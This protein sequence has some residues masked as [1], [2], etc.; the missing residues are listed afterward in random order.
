MPPVASANLLQLLTI[1]DCV[2]PG[3]V[4]A[5]EVAAEVVVVVPPETPTQY[6]S[7]AQNE[8]PQFSPLVP[9]TLFQAYSCAGVM[10]FCVA[11]S[12]H[13]MPP[14]ASAYLLH[15]LIIPD[16]VGPG[17]DT[18]VVDVVGLLVPGH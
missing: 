1:P 10:P 7:L 18:D 13:P 5:V 12:E 6:D 17:V 16:W 8:L 15:V 9:S 4:T 2:G 3:A 11:K 14:V